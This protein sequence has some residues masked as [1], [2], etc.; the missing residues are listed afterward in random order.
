MIEKF[1]SDMTSR[2]ISSVD[3]LNN[4]IRSNIQVV[5]GAAREKLLTELTGILY[6]LL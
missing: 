6:K 3:Q 1:K 2:H 5:G 4:T